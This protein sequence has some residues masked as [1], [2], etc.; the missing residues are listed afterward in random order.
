MHAQDV[1]THKKPPCPRSSYRQ[2]GG[3]YPVW[4]EQGWRAARERTAAVRKHEPGDAEAGAQS[5]RMSQKLARQSERKD[6]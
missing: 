5:S 3:G 2:A 6:S 1:K 4:K